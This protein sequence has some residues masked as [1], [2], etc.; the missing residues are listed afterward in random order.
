MDIRNNILKNIIEITIDNNVINKDNIKIEFSTNKYSSVKKDMWHIVL[1]NKLLSKHNNYLF[2]YKC[3]NCN[4][5]HIVSSTQFLRKINKG[6]IYCGLCRNDII[7]TK[8]KCIK[9]NVNKEDN[10]EEKSNK[11]PIELKKESIDAFDDY[12]DDYKS[13]YYSFHLTN[14]DY[15]RISTRL[16]SLQND[17]F[18]NIKDYEFWS[19]FKTSNQMKFTSVM[20]DKVNNI[21][22]KA[23]QPIMKCDNCSAHWRAKSLEK[24]KND[25][26]ILCKDCSLVNK[27]FNIR[28]TKNINNE[29]ILYQS[30]LELKFIN[31]CNSNNIIVHNG[32][33]V[34][35][36][37]DNKERI[38]KVD[39]LISKT[40]IEIKDNHIWHKNDLKSGK[41]KA[42]EDAVYELI[43]KK[44]YDN[45]YL[46]TPNNWNLYL[47]KIN[48]I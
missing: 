10:V 2:K 28:T 34:K 16:I 12:D 25:I 17:K 20:Y 39:F 42:K 22:F 1:D 41:W 46:I 19:V 44:E 15:N 13:N 27:T 6:S 26:K 29:Q 18:N 38:Y 33:K 21:I 40:L 36:F 8:R 37:F 5:I 24:F 4:A 35:Y 23:H 3:V 45:Y 9:D 11:T 31:W 30:K 7:K 14:E 43:N 48:K 32:P 47:D